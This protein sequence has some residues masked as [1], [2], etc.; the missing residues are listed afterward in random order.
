MSMG[1]LLI[2][3]AA[4][5]LLA[6]AQAAAARPDCGPSSGR[7]IERSAAVRVYYTEPGPRKHY[8]ACWRRTHGKPVRLVEGGVERPEFVNR[9]LLRGRYLT[10]VYTTCSTVTGCDSFVVE[11]VDVKSRFVVASTDYLG[12]SV[13]TLFATRGGAA[14]FL[15]TDR[16]QQYVQRLD[17]LGVEEID[18][19]PEVHSLTLHGGRLH[20]LHGTEPRDE[21][22]AH[23]LRCGPEKGAYTQELS[24]RI[25]VYVT[26]P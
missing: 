9:F 23:V 3:F 24:K 21:H 4:A 6:P 16:G 19:G 1:R 15:A 13:R 22:I 5:A 12:G 2:V 25:R 7:T 17:S 8:F 18:F 14:A 11:T 10:F 20:W 26:D